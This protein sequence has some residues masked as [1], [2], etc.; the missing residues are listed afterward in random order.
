MELHGF[1]KFTVLS[2]IN[3]FL[4]EIYQI[5]NFLTDFVC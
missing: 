2:Q 5:L 1:N 3:L 4:L